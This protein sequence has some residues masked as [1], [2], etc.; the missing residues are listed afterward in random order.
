LQNEIRFV[1]L[2]FCSLTSPQ[3]SVNE[4]SNIKKIFIK[5]IV[6]A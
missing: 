1:V 2:L 6:Q 3:T 5:K 4:P